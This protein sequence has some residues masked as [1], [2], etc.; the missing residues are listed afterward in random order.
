MVGKLV[1]KFRRK[2]TATMLTARQ[3]ETLKN[4]GRHS[5]GNNLYLNIAKGG[6]KSWVFF[7]RSPSGRRR[8]MGLG[9]IAKVSL[10]N[11]RKKAQDANRLLSEGIDPLVAE[12]AS[13]AANSRIQT[14]GEFADDYMK[15]HLPKFRN[16][17]HKAQWQM[18]LREY[19]KP[20]RSMPVN[21]IDT[22]AILKVLRPIWL[23]KPETAS[24]IRGRIENILDAARAQG[25]R[26][27]DNPAR[28]KG[29]LK[30]VLP[31]RQRLTRGHHAALPYDDLPAF[32]LDLRSKQSTAA[33]ALELCILT[34]TRSNETLNATWAEFD[35]TKAIWTIPAARMKAGHE[36]RV[37]LTARALE[38]L[39]NLKAGRRE[40]NPFVFLGNSASK[41]LSSMAMIM[42]LRRMGRDNITVHGFRSTFRD[43]A[44]EQTSIPMKPVSMHW[45]IVSATRQKPPTGAEINLR[46]V[47]SSWKHG[48]HSPH[49]QVSQEC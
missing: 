20:L 7:Y 30:A 33:L 32:M 42:Q 13:K 34:A 6:S 21:A 9:S 24:R 28:W 18:T 41:P 15:L 43:W 4:P 31:A 49:D 48:T 29:H 47:A 40:G 26:D 35:L 39:T 14:F 8:E 37:P 11:A 10:A 36:H 25:L 12:R 16:D 22:E 46:S 38:I 17:K 23:T 19:C 27:G 3:V 1:G 2:L 5:A 45:R 44:S